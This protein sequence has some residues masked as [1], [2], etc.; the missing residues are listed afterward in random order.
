MKWIKASDRQPDDWKS[1][2]IRNTTGK[3]I[4]VSDWMVSLNGIRIP[5]QHDFIW[6][7]SDFEWLDE[8]TSD[9]EQIISE[10][11]DMHPYKES[12]N[13]ESYSQYNEGWADACDILGNRIL[14]VL[15]PQTPDK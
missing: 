8:S 3:K 15:K 11:E 12:G 7:W 1:I 14:E 5:P 2:I 9:I 6:R 13:R 10:V 4:I